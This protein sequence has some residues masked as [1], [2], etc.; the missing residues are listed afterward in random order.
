M[1]FPA[2]A[3]NSMANSRFYDAMSGPKWFM[4]VSKYGHCDFYDS[5]AKKLS[6]KF[7]PTCKQHCNF[8]EYRAMLKEAMVSFIHGILNNDRQNLQKIETGNFKIAS[9]R[10]HDYMGYE[11]TIR[12]FCDRVNPSDSPKV[13]Q[14]TTQ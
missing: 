5:S 1:G 2:C 13:V 14:L 3:P 9:I 4:N 6:K 8:P 7:C 11:S 10:K 12:P